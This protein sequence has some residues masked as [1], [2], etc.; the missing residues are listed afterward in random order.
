MTSVT[1]SRNFVLWVLLVRASP[2]NITVKHN[3]LLQR[4]GG[5]DPQFIQPYLH[6]VNQFNFPISGHIQYMKAV[7]H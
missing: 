5:K 2:S 6:L 7:F 4:Y 1:E 3:I